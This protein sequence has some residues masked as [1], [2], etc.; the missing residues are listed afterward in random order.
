MTDEG[1]GEAAELMQEVLQ[2]VK[3]LR[4]QTR[5]A[6]KQGAGPA[7]AAMAAEGAPAAND[8]DDGTP[9]T[10]AAAP[11]A[12]IAAALPQQ[13]Q[14]QPPPL[15]PQQQLQPEEINYLGIPDDLLTAEQIKIKRRQQ[16]LHAGRV[17]REKAA[18]RRA[19]AA[20][21]REEQARAEDRLLMAD[22]FTY[23]SGVVCRH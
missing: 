1:L 21:E 4:K 3:V 13:Q 22:P 20:A 10:T 9:T 19:A 17:G 5:D 2:Q 11:R 8:A 23:L 16:L 14:Q 7:G 15:P 18:A 6:G 12:D